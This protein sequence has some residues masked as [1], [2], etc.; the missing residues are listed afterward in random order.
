[1]GCLYLIT[2]PSGKSYIG[3]TKRSLQSRVDEHCKSSQLIGRAI[4][5]YGLPNMIITEL[6]QA[7]DWAILQA[8]EIQTIAAIGSKY[9]K[10]YNLTDGGDGNN[11]QVFTYATR[12][13]ISAK[14]KG[15]VKSKEHIAKI[16]AKLKGRK[17]DDA[18]RQRAIAALNY[19]KA[20][21]QY[22]KAFRAWVDSDACANHLRNLAK[23]GSIAS[24]TPEAIEKWR[25]S[26]EGFKFSEEVKLKISQS[27]SKPKPAGFNEKVKQA[28]AARSPEAKAKQAAGIAA[29]WAK[30][31]LLKEQNGIST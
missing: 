15:F 14:V 5:K 1:M 29:A 20:T 25:K 30:K 3:I 8:L 31:R 23:T 9:P 6:E 21:A 12:Q 19:G 7:S 16:V 10:G 2:S 28:L 13:K 26:R 4:R 17:L 22:Q 27:N 18:K 11:N 24:K